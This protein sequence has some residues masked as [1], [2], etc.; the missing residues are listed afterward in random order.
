MVTHSN[1]SDPELRNLIRYKKITLGGNS[2]L[3]IY[4]LLSCRSGR[5]MKRENR[6]FFYGVN[7]AIDHG[8]RPCGNCLAAEYKKWK[9]GSV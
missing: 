6:I 1:I 5:R 8:Y 9:N 2:R 3:K 7:E 4:G